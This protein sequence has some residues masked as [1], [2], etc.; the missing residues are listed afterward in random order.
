MSFHPIAVRLSNFGACRTTVQVAHCTSTES[1]FGFVELQC[2]SNYS[3]RR[4]TVRL[5]GRIFVISGEE[6][7][8]GRVFVVA[9]QHC[10]LGRARSAVIFQGRHSIYDL[11][12]RTL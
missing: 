11:L 10:S 12:T 7:L 2:M 8:W 6:R 5:P 9:F 3:A 4:T 1:K